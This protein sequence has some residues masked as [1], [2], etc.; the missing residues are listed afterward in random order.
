MGPNSDLGKAGLPEATKRTWVTRHRI[1]GWRWWV[2]KM[3]NKD[4]V[5]GRQQTL[6]SLVR[7]LDLS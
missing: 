6:G 2:G 1:W 5:V 7:I 3:R 4:G